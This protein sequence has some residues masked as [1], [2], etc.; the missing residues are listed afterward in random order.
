[1]IPPMNHQWHGWHENSLKEVFPYEHM[2]EYTDKSLRNMGLDHIDLMQVHVWD[3]TW[4]DSEDWQ[5]A[6]QDLKRQGK[7]RAFGISINRW[8]PDNVI[9]A[10][11]TG[12]V[13]AVQVISNIFDQNPEDNLFPVCQELNI[14]VLA[15]VP[16][17]EGSL[18]G[19]LTKKSTW[20]QGDWRN[21]YFTR[22]NLSET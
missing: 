21:E 8:Q 10:M 5:K 12:L 15:R 13:D 7:I 19:N 16:F 18:I 6:V 11:L 14:G 20:P 22:K 17:D 4:T 9:K 3:D 1:M 2:I